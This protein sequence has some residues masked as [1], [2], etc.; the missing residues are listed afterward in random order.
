MFR[1]VM[2]SRLRGMGTRIRTR[3][4]TDPKLQVRLGGAVVLASA[5]GLCLAVRPPAVLTFLLGAT[6]FNLVIG[7]TEARWRLYG[8]RDP[9]ADAQIAWPDPGPPG[10]GGRALRPLAPPPAAAG[11]GGDG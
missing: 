10:G 11:A 3:I 1:A 9:S 6:A 7:G 4:R 5:V 8:W 2:R